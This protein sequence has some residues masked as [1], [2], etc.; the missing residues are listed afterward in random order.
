MGLGADGHVGVE[1]ASF[2]LVHASIL[3]QPAA[4]PVKLWR[5]VVDASGV[6]AR[7]ID[8]IALRAHGQALGRGSVLLDEHLVIRCASA[9]CRSIFGYDPLAL[10][11][12]SATELVHP[13]DL[14]LV[15][16]ILTYEL[17]ADVSF[18]AASSSR[19]TLSFGCSGATAR[20][21]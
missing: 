9:S 6:N 16:E 19:S 11:G 7:S 5:M 3:A 12:R 2:G 18:R 1:L 10:V 17:T 15:A 13:D 4:S 14:G 20:H 8:D 21:I